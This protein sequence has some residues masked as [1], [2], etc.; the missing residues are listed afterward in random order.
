M[1]ELHEFVKKLEQRLAVTP[2]PEP[3]PSQTALKGR[4]I[5]LWSTRAGRLLLVADE[6]D[7]A[8]AV[9]R[10]QARRGEI[11]TAAE[12]RRIV[13]VN[14]PAV[15][16]E[17]HEWKRKFDGRVREFERAKSGGEPAT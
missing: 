8:Q 11:Y 5:E 15:V 4:V 3:E 2:R 7:A 1:S 9:E 13:A 12:V 10:F 6:T 14:D 16:A 17:I